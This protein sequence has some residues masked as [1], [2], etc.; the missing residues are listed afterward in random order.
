[1]K[2]YILFLLLLPSLSFC[3]EQCPEMSLADKV[4]VKSGKKLDQLPDYVLENIFS[5][6]IDL[7]ELARVSKRFSRL[8][9]LIYKRRWEWLKAQEEDESGP[10]IRTINLS[11]KDDVSYRD[12]RDLYQFLSKQIG[13]WDLVR[14]EDTDISRVDVL[15]D[16]D[17]KG[18]DCLE[19]ALPK[20]SDHIGLR[21]SEV[22]DDKDEL[23]ERILN[24]L[25]DPENLPKMDEALAEI[26]KSFD[27]NRKG[28]VVYNCKNI[29]LARG[30]AEKFS[31]SYGNRALQMS[32]LWCCADNVRF[33]LKAGANVNCRFVDG[34]TLLMASMH[35]YNRA[36][37]IKVLLDFG[38]D[39]DA[40][41]G[42]GRTA[43]KYAMDIYAFNSI[44]TLLEKGIKLSDQDIFELFNVIEDCSSALTDWD[45]VG[46]V[47]ELLKRGVSIPKNTK[48]FDSP[49]IRKMLRE[50]KRKRALAAMPKRTS[51]RPMITNH[52]IL[53]YPLLH[54]KGVYY[55]PVLR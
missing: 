14:P 46:I 25:N 7:A 2:L 53:A 40:V 22:A 18:L 29:L 11:D 8:L 54:R 41:D 1:M 30:S 23:L 9:K 49:L 24:W 44:S 36:G 6:G 16:M 4:V 5:C 43:L 55:Y 39:I 38:I 48:R 13:D 21:K 37:A 34:T 19:K 12:F 32:V 3:M 31:G 10:R 50:E 28:S 35:D 52:V 45:C 20:L 17:Q 51:V 27:F 42:N 26:C 15:V 33:L 47:E